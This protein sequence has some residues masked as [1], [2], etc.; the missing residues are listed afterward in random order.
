[1][2]NTI[3][4]NR[5]IKLSSGD[6]VFYLVVNTVMI[7]IGLL[8]AVPLDLTL[9]DRV[10]GVVLA[11]TLEVGVFVAHGVLGVLGEGAIHHDGA[12]IVVNSQSI[13]HGLV[14]S[15]SWSMWA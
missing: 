6:R 14:L 8:V 11:D 9:D 4:K 2:S 3:T 5:K 10:V 13:L 1:M 15:F 7:L 12:S